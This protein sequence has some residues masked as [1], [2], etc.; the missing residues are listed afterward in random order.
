MKIDKRYLMKYFHEVAVKQKSSE[1]SKLGY[2]VNREKRIGNYIADLVAIKGK[3]KIYFEFKVSKLKQS[4]KQNI[5]QIKRLIEKEQ[6]NA[7]FKLVNVTP[8]EEI[9]IE[10]EGL[11]EIIFEYFINEP[12]PEISTLSTHSTVSDVIDVEIYEIK[13]S[14]N[15]LFFKGTF[16]LAVTLQYGSDSDMKNDLGLETSDSFVTSFDM[17]TDG[18]LNILSLNARVD[19]SGWSE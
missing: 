17:I 12:P 18:Q 9:Q 13:I 7:K 15:E 14:P 1:Y 3:E 11:E 16:I 10:V 6:P 2:E 8:P 4:Q 19:T 5:L